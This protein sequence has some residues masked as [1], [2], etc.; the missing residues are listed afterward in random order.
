M[1]NRENLAENYKHI[2]GWGID[3]DLENEPTYP[4]KNYTGDD[5]KRLNYDR[6][7]QQPVNVEVLHSNE[8]PSV[9]AAFGATLPPSGLSGVIRRQAFKFSEGKI[10]HWL[11][12]LAADRVNVIEGVI[13]D[14][15]QGHF[16]NTF[17]E[18]GGKAQ[19]EHKP[20]WLIKK[21][22]VVAVVAVGIIAVMNRD[23]LK[24]IASKKKAFGRARFS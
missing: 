2:N 21:V 1:E 4:M 15:K 9:S 3:A 19:W 18:K 16:P 10:E 17:A 8:R 20:E 22:A 7:P 12:L 24:N 13:D 6:P 23:K 5:H 14:L 11:L